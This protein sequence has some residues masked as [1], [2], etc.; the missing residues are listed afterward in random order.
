MQLSFNLKL[1]MPRP[2]KKLLH[3]AFVV[4][5]SDDEQCVDEDWRKS[6]LVMLAVDGDSNGFSRAVDG[7]GGDFPGWEKFDKR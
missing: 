1:S 6:A 7:N 2:S 3:C 4:H 5:F